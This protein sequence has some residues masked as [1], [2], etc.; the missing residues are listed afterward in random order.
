MDLPEGVREEVSILEAQLAEHAGKVN[1]LRTAVEKK[2]EEFADARAS[3]GLFGRIMSPIFGGDDNYRREK[4]LKAAIPLLEARLAEERAAT[5][6]YEAQVISVLHEHFMRNDSKYAGFAKQKQMLEPLVAALENYVNMATATFEQIEHSEHVYQVTRK[7]MEHA[8]FP[9][10]DYFDYA[11]A[12]KPVCNAKAAALAL[13][14][15]LEAYAAST[16]GDAGRFG[17]D[18]TSMDSLPSGHFSSVDLMLPYTSECPNEAKAALGHH[19]DLAN[20][21]LPTTKA[22]LAHL[23]SYLSSALAAARA[24]CRSRSAQPADDQ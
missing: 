16:K 3:V 24:E 9:L 23:S 7:R 19:Q 1:A 17:N 5:T 10:A 11:Q 13:S 22:R 14:N 21:A 4:S 18:E 20:I 15:A 6:Q 8:K 12:R 2:K